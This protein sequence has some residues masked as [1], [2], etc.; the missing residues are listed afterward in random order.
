MIV[1]SR[2]LGDICADTNGAAPGCAGPQGSLSYDAGRA[3]QD[4]AA[5][6]PA[7]SSSQPLLGIGKT[8]WTL[9]NLGLGTA[10][11][12]HGVKKKSTLWKAFGVGWFLNA[13]V[14]ETINPMRLP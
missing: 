1:S 5:A 10:A 9:I 8:G 7:P 6:Q 14:I 12:V 4:A 3:V 2:G 13:V 11:M